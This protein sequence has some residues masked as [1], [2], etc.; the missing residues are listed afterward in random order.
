[1]SD[2]FLA[3]E[4]A[5]LGSSFSPNVTSP[6]GEIDFDAAASAFPDIDIDGDAPIPPPT[7]TRSAGG[8]DLLDGFGDFGGGTPLTNGGGARHDIKVTGDDEVDR[9][10]SEF[11]D[12]GGVSS[13][14]YVLS[15]LRRTS[16]IRLYAVL[17][18]VFPTCCPPSLH[19]VFHCA[20]AITTF[21][22]SACIQRHRARR[23]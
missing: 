6:S 2:D 10:E 8:N 15:L 12:I 3:R 7:T 19:S 22:P 13:G 4:A 20:T 9:F 21:V 18:C 14:D 23:R 11:P 17:G 5:V 1:M 16:E